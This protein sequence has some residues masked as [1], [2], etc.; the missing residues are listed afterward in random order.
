MY[1]LPFFNIYHRGQIFNHAFKVG[2]M[3]R[4]V[5]DLESKVNINKLLGKLNEDILKFPFWMYLPK[6]N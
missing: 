2:L 6:V 5:Y 1:N 4:A 3:K